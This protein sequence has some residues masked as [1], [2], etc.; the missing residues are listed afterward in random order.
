MEGGQREA[1]AA[2]SHFGHR[3][4]HSFPTTLLPG[5]DGPVSSSRSSESACFV[6]SCGFRLPEVGF[7]KFRK[8]QVGGS[9]LL[10]GSTPHFV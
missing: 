1:L 6:V 8:P 10:A 3:F 7:T 2:R 9:I 5:Q 4:S